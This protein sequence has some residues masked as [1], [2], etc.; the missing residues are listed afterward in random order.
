LVVRASSSGIAAAT[1]AA[2][3]GSK[4]ILLAEFLR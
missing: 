1:S 3:G 4:V 2:L